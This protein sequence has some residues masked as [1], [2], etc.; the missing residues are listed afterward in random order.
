MFTFESLCNYTFCRHCIE[1]GREFNIEMSRDAEGKIDRLSVLLDGNDITVKDGKIFVNAIKV[2]VPYDNKMLRIKRYGLSFKLVSRRG[3]LTL[4][5]NNED[6]LSLILHKKYDTCGLCGD[7]HTIIGT[8]ITNL[9][10]DSKVLDNTC[11]EPSVEQLLHCAEGQ[12]YCQNIITK[13]FRPCKTVGNLYSEYERICTEEYCRT[14]NRRDVCPTFFELARECSSEGSGPYESWRNDQDV[15]CATPACPQSEIYQ[16]C[17]PPNKPTCSYMSPY[18]DGGCVSGCACPEGYVL[19][20]IGGSGECIAKRNCACKFNGKVYSPGEDK[21]WSLSVEIRPCFNGP[22]ETCL[23]SVTLSL[24]PPVSADKYIF[25]SNGSFFNA[26]IHHNDY[27][28]SD[29]IN[30]FRQSSSY[31][32]V[33]TFYGL[34]LLIQYVPVMQFYASLPAKQFTNTQGLCGSFNNIAEDDFLSSQNILE[35]TSEAFASSWEMMTCPKARHPSCTSIEKERFAKENC[36][37][38]I[39]PNGVFASGHFTVDHRSYYERCLIS[40]CVCENVEDCLCTALGN[41]VKACAKHGIYITDWRKGICEEVCKEGMVFQYNA[42]ACN[43]SCRSLSERDL[44]CDVENIP[45][46]GC[47]CPKDRYLNSKGECV[48]QDV[49]D[50]YM[51]NQVLTSGQSIQLVFV[52]EGKFFAMILL[53]SAL[54]ITCTGGAE[55]VSCSDPNAKKRIDR[56]CSALKM[57]Q[58]SMDLPCKRGCFCPLGKVR[59]SNGVC[60][61]AVHCPCSYSGRTYKQGSSIKVECNTCKCV[62]GSWKCTENKCQS[63]C[64]IYGDGQI[65]TFDGKWYSYDGLC[66][67]VLAEDYCGK[68]D[69]SFQILTESVPCCDDGVTCSRKITVILQ[70]A[71]LVLEDGKVMFIKDAGSTQCERDEQPYTV[72]TVGLYLII[73]F[74]HG[75]ILI[76]D[77]NTRITLIKEPNWSSNVCG[78]CGNHNGNLQDEFTTRQGSLAA[79]PLEFGNSWK[80]GPECSDTVVESFPCDANAYCRDWAVRKCEIIRDYRFRACHNRVDPTPYHK[81]C[82]EEACACTMEGK[83]LGFCTAVAMYAEACSAVGVCVS[84]RTPDLCPVYCDYYNAPGQCS[85]HYEPCGT[86]TAKTCKD[87]VIGRTLPSVLEGCYAKCPKKTPYLDENTMKCVRLKD[88]S[89]YYNDVI[90]AGQSIYDDCGR[91]CVCKAGKLVCSPFPVPEFSVTPTLKKTETT[92]TTKGPVSTNIVL[93]TGKEFQQDTTGLPGV[94]QVTR[95]G[96]NKSSTG[97]TSE[98]A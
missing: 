11:P 94:T 97:S 53:T 78:L 57:P 87:Q 16:D 15:V 92:N 49:C 26:Q 59:N 9:I 8:N 22:A 40:T 54:V 52:E 74:L 83:Y 48:E 80:T 89:C 28:A 69:G 13:Y 66:Q 23:K 20:D 71:S 85:W 77:K 1:S 79:G 17:F 95:A 47:I 65:Q 33:S 98:S 5:W 29:T 86:V 41:Y 91:L 76:W 31:I 10:A 19:D 14:G 88:C 58:I 63:T 90:I 60:I 37:L 25:H 18:Q 75:L 27:Y 34:H 2:Q 35:V 6:K 3:I 45:V 68:E 43:T 21:D 30:I 38:L 73:K 70:N 24:G 81:A 84:W 4:L 55:F 82:I 46:D 62:Q 61:P 42:K 64:H 32:G 36:G 96:W 7:S 50:C 72:H 51:D 56:T 12:M 67:Y 93:T 39:D 44:S